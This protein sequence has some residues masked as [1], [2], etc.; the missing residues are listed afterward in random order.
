[1]GTSSRVCHRCKDRGGG[2]VQGGRDQVLL[3]IHLLL[4]YSRF[5]TSIVLGAGFRPEQPDNTN[6]MS[7]LSHGSP[8]PVGDR[9]SSERPPNM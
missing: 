6:T 9:L 5:L 4:K 3:K 2:A 7:P 8:S 1:M